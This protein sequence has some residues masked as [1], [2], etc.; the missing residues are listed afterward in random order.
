MPAPALAPALYIVSTPIGHLKDITLRALETL[1]AADI[2]ACEDTRH[3]RKLLDHYAIA[4]KLT[5]YHEHNAAKA[6]PALLSALADGKAVAL[7]SDAGTPLISDPGF[8][9][10]V[11]AVEQG[12]SVVPIPGAS[13]LLSALVAAGLPTDQ[14]HFAGF[15]PPKAAARDRAISKL[16]GV[17][18]TLIFYEAPQ[19]IAPA[20]LALSRG[21]GP[22]RPACLS[23]EMTKRFEQHVRG[24]LAELAEHCA[25][26]PPKGECVV[27]VSGASQVALIIDD[28]TV[29]QMLADAIADIGVKRAADAVAQETGLNKRDLYARAVTL[30]KQNG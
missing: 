9:L 24:T 1:A 14:F 7:I 4:S 26:E 27:L 6:R 12:V 23:R 2:I 21:L 3:S 10:V 5:P 11:D 13:A 25:A 29:D 18:A 30:S 15:L 20:L 17:E 19:R 16:A 28:E 22:D 8:K